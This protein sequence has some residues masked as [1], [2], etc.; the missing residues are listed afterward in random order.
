MNIYKSKDWH[1][2]N[3]SNRKKSN[4]NKGK[5]PSLI[6]GSSGDGKKY[7]NMGL[8]HSEKRG[9]H[10]N[11]SI[12]DPTNWNKTSYIRDDVRQ[13]DINKLKVVLKDYKLNPKDENKILKIL[14]KYKKKNSH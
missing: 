9:H 8:T 7:V 6:V 10:K 12:S 13:D 14:E 4:K 1:F 5:H 11:I 3:N 2:R